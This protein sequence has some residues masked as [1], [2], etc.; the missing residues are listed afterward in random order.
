MILNKYLN[1]KYQRKYSGEFSENAMVYFYLLFFDWFCR[2][3]IGIF[4]LGN[5][6]NNV[7]VIWVEGQHWGRG[8]FLHILHK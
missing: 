1:D 8:N 4:I 5:F 3:F 2:F 6:Q 7:V